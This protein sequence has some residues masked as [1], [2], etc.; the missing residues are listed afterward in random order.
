[1]HVSYSERISFLLTKNVRGSTRKRLKLYARAKTLSK[2]SKKRINQL[3]N[4]HKE[5]EQELSNHPYGGL[6]LSKYVFVISY[7]GKDKRAEID[8]DAFIIAESGQMRTFE[9]AMDA[10]I[11]DR[12]L[13]FAEFRLGTADAGNLTKG[14]IEM[15]GNERF[16]ATWKKIATE[17]ML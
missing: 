3:Y 12:C 1:M 4:Y 5:D 15:R 13:V 14:H 8:F 2:K 10:F 6:G 11:L 17:A 9:Q 16:K 7:K